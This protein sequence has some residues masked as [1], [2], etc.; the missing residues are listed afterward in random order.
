MG[1]NASFLS[2]PSLKL[3]RFT[4]PFLMYAI[5]DIKVPVTVHAD[6]TVPTDR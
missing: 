6:L 3:V 1:I 4:A 5:G 2:T